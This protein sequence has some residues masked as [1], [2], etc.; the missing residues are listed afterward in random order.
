VPSSNDEQHAEQHAEQQQQGDE[1]THQHLEQQPQYSRAA[2]EGL[3]IHAEPIWPPERRAQRLS[4]ALLTI[5]VDV[6]FNCA[7]SAWHAGNDAHVTFVE[8]CLF[9]E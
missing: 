6:S 2:S 9:D 3:D 7:P 5:L 8:R 1:G 4:F